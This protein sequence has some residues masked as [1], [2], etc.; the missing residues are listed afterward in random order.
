VIRRVSS[1]YWRIDW[2]GP[3]EV[4]LSLVGMVSHGNREYHGK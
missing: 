1:G 3:S 2:R 4:A